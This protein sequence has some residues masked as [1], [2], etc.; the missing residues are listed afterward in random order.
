MERANRRGNQRIYLKVTV[1][2]LVI[3]VLAC[4]PTVTAHAVNKATGHVV[5]EA[6]SLRVLY[7]KDARVRL[8]P[9]STTKILTAITVLENTDVTKTVIIP[10]QAQGV[11]GSSVYLKAGEKWTVLDLLYG[12]MLRSGN[13]CAVA[14][15]VAVG[16]SVE[17]FTEMMNATARKSGAVESAFTNPHGLHNDA[18]YTTAYDL[19][20]ITAYAFRNELF[21]EIIG[22]K[23]HEYTDGDGNKAVFY[24]KNKLLSSF[25][26]ANGVKTGYTKASGRCLVSSAYREN[27]QLICVV[28]NEYDMW[29]TSKKLLTDA[30]AAYDMR[31]IFKANANMEVRT[32]KTIF[33]LR[34]GYVKRDRFY[35]LTAQE[36]A[37]LRLDYDL[38]RTALPLKGAKIGLVSAYLDNHLLFSEELFSM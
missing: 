1:I 35:P 27:M 20:L 13:D 17:R 6:E 33:S 32:G 24:N 19:A 31:Q 5:I 16:G 28:L 9:A 36:A 29:E 38:K 21:K 34:N 10:R 3:A 22:S 7:E 12:L 18:H 11:E 14:L 2:L 26:G 8:E 4:T 25:E 30:F 23:K 15:A 37:E